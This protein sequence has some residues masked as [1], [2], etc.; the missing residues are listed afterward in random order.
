MHCV[1]PPL[2]HDVEAFDKDMYDCDL[3][4]EDDMICRYDVKRQLSEPAPPGA[5]LFPKKL[6]SA[7]MKDI[8]V[9]G[10]KGACDY[11]VSEPEIET[12]PEKESEP[13]CYSCDAESCGGDTDTSWVIGG[14][15]RQ[16]TGGLSRQVTGSVS[17]QVT[18]FVWPV[19]TAS[20]QI[21]EKIDVKSPT[22][23]EL[24]CVVMDATCHTQSPQSPVPRE[25]NVRYPCQTQSL[26][27]SPMS[28]L[29]GEATFGWPK[30]DDENESEGAPEQNVLARSVQTP[31]FSNAL[32]NSA[33]SMLAANAL[34]AANGVS[35]PATVWTNVYTVML[36]N[37]P[38]KVS[39]ALLRSEM[40]EAG[41]ANAYDFVYLPLDPNTKANRGYAFINFRSPGMASMFRMNFDGRKFSHFNT[42]KVMSTVPA[43]LQGFEANYAHYTRARKK[44]RDIGV[45]QTFLRDPQPGKGARLGRKKSG[46]QLE[47]KRAMEQWQQDHM[48]PNTA[49]RGKPMAQK[50]EPSRAPRFCPFCG[51][52]FRPDFKFCQ[53]CGEPAVLV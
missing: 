47:E 13:G 36:Q 44:N 41:F 26:C 14:P 16:V 35:N 53:F 17:R 49:A 27:S 46:Y 24:P 42:D 40:D 20:V 37:I 32:R 2:S 15:N 12:E 3:D 30:T 31:A 50:P 23:E 33:T 39:Q 52:G 11:E 10:T 43:T 4:V 1:Q 34:A 38:N 9:D 5:S 25:S 8:F 22:M 7:L 48:C 51:E 21:D 6:F 29:Q 18:D 28:Q 45:A 19:S